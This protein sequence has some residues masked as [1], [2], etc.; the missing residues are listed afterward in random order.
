VQPERARLTLR[1]YG[2][3][4]SPAAFAVFHSSAGSVVEWSETLDVAVGP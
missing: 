3:A 1:V 2:V 4:D